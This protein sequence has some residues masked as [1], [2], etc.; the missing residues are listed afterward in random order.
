MSLRRWVGLAAAARGRSHEARGVGCEDV[1]LVRHG[2]TF[3]AALADG[4]GSARHAR[5]GAETVVRALADLLG[6]ELDALLAGDAASARARILAALDGALAAA[7]RRFEAQPRD[8]ASTLLFVAARGDRVLGGQLGDGVLAVRRGGRF[9]VMFEPA[10]GEFASQTVFVPAR[11][12]AGD[13]RL[14]VVQGAA[15]EGV[16]LMSDGAAASLAVKVGD[17]FRVAPALERWWAGLSTHLPDAVVAALDDGL[18]THLRARTGD[19]CALV[20]ARTIDARDPSARGWI[21]RGARARRRLARA[22][23]HA[24][25]H[26]HDSH[27]LRRVA[28]RASLSVRVARRHARALAALGWFARA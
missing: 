3:V 8:L 26:A 6:R 27:G 5:L 11:R 14:F 12:G 10:T 21:G 9:E 1:V 24:H 15:V 28:R 16:A 19:D 23:G 2:P 25:D 17:A 18:R 13:L 20:L 22:L 7:A 4:A